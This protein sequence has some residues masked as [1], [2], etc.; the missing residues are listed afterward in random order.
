MR[1]F[2]I[3]MTTPLWIQFLGP[4]KV[5]INLLKIQCCTIKDYY[6]FIFAIFRNAAVLYSPFTKSECIVKTLPFL[7]IPYLPFFIFCLSPPPL[8]LPPSPLQMSQASWRSTF[9]RSCS[10]VYP[11]VPLCPKSAIAGTPTRWEWDQT[12]E[13]NIGDSEMNS[14]FSAGDSSVANVTPRDERE[15]NKHNDSFLLW[16]FKTMTPWQ[17]KKNNIQAQSL[18][19]SATECVFHL[20][21]CSLLDLVI[22]TTQG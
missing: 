17:R 14:V 1:T 11:N 10:S 18:N 4:L 21:F 2:L 3:S 6:Y 16:V 20:T 15:V 8:P 22:Q 5:C 7:I 9:P 12:Q 19:P 13:G